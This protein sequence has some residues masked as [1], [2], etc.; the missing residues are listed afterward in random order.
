[1]PLLYAYGALSLAV[2]RSGADDRVAGATSSSVAVVG[3]AI[4][5]KVSG[6]LAVTVTVV[7]ATVT[8]TTPPQELSS[9]G[10]LASG[11]TL[12]VC[13]TTTTLSSPPAALVDTEP[14]LAP[15]SDEAGVD[16][17]AVE[18]V[19]AADDAPVPDGGVYPG[20][21]DGELLLLTVYTTF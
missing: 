8:V 1:V 9:V 4:A 12:L 18:P 17:A 20:A 11:I 13:V 5:E 16:G 6:I 15:G 7:R 10:K 19:A 3:T 2:V 14:G 21:P